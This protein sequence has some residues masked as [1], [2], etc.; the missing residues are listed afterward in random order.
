VKQADVGRSSEDLRRHVV[1]EGPN[2]PW[3][4]PVF[5][6]QKKNGDL[7]FCE[8][9]S[10]FNHVT[11]KDCFALPRIDDTLDTPAGAKWFSTLDLKS[12]YWQVALHAGDK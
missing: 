1:T 3:S 7:R 6:L 8:D 2:S 9:C 10:K 5:L 11:K 4:F 12:G